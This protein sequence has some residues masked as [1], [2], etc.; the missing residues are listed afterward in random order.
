MLDIHV[1]S[2]RC[3]AILDTSRMKNANKELISQGQRA[4]YIFRAN[5]SLLRYLYIY[6]IKNYNARDRFQRERHH[7][8][9]N[10]SEMTM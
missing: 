1:S 7:T 2:Y 8:N 3:D 6:N 10:S 9:Q 5:F 4:A